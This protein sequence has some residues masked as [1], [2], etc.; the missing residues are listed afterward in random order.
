MTFERLE[1]RVM[2]DSG[3]PSAIVLGRTL[4]VPQPAS[5][6]SAALPSYFVGEV[7][8]NQV[9]ITYTVYNEQSDPE[10]GVSLTTTLGPGV[11]IASDSQSAVQSG[12]NL[13]W[14]LGTIQGLE[15]SSVTL[16]VN[17]P[18]PTTT[19][20]DTGAQVVATLDGASVSTTTPAA[21]LSPGNVESGLLAST[22]DAN[23]TDPFIQQEA[24]E[25]NYDPT[26]IFDFLH[27]QI[28]FNSYI[29]SVR[30]A[31]GTLWADAGNSLDVASLGIALMRAS[32][33]PAQYV[34]GT[35]LQSQAQSLILS[36]FPEPD[37][38]SGLIPAGATLS[39][40]ANDPELL[41]ETENHYW[42]QFNS[43]SGMQDADPLIAGATVGQ[44]FTTA[45][46]TFAEVPDDLRETTEIQLVAE[47]T[48][49][50]SSLFGQ[51]GQSDTTVLD[52]TFNDVDLVGRPLSIGNFVSTNT[53]S[54]LIASTTTNTYSPFIAQNDDAYPSTQS[55]L[56]RGTSYQEVLTTLPFGSEVLTGLFLTINQSGPQ[57]PTQ[58][59]ERTLYDAIGYAARQNGGTSS[60]SINP[61]GGP[62]VS[63]LSVWTVNVQPG[64]VAT[65]AAGTV[66]NELTEV[67]QQISADQAAGNVDPGEE[68]LEQRDVMLTTELNA[69]DFFFA[70]NISLL[71]LESAGLITAYYVRPRVLI[72]SGVVTTPAG[73]TTPTLTFAIDLRNDAIRAIAFPGQN[74]AAIVAF[75]LAYGIFENVAEAEVLTLNAAPGSTQPT[76]VNSTS[77]LEQADAGDRARQ[78]HHGEPVGAWLALDLGRRQGPD[79]D[80]SR[81]GSARDRAEPERAGQWRRHRRMVRDRP[82]HRANHRRDPGRR[83]PGARRICCGRRFHRGGDG[84]CILQHSEA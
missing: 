82:D 57:G 78:H 15:R 62:S 77:I 32:G 70:S 4:T 64:P 75:N 44:S 63:P 36:M 66:I 52:Q 55:D 45:S 19:Q 29:G 17:L 31:R 72:S 46:T 39:D 25:L 76:P 26:Q 20:L 9:A 43:G 33:I 11:T 42:F 34:G 23:T 84:L 41:S 16:T 51:S 7:Q 18:G 1:E 58:S 83:E 21:V 79:H 28:G 71:G 14:N 65:T 22:P 35:L 68:A 53:V 13:A 69:D 48:N 30:R 56:I 2:L 6:T 40:P 5:S 49:T 12:Q 27:T 38:I 81:R 47:I 37:R 60:T 10:T 61:A 80:G 67:Q 8:S 24:A 59:Y 73:S 50:A 3:L 54:A 74:T